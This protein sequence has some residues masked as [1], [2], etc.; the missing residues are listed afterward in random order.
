M[1][2][3]PSPHSVQYLQSIG[4]LPRTKTVPQTLA[5]SVTNTLQNNV[6]PLTT[7]RILWPTQR[8]ARTLDDTLPYIPKAR[9]LWVPWLGACGAL[10]AVLFSPVV[11]GHA[12]VP[13]VETVLSPLPA[14]R[15][16]W[17]AKSPSV[18]NPRV[19]S[20]ASGTIQRATKCCCLGMID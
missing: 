15:G 10:L 3:S 11:W 13:A 7:E 9:S 19:L 8:C 6:P 17:F 18:P 5:K 14:P 20:S 4:A 12:F 16:T 2:R 1:L